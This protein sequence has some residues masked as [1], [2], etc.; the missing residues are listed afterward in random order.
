MPNPIMVCPCC[1]GPA[2]TA[3]DQSRFE[4]ACRDCTWAGDHDELVPV[5][6]TPPTMPQ[7][8]RV[9]ARVPESENL[10]TMYAPPETL[11]D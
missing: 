8:R 4:V 7:A 1:H 9:L 2:Y 11:E 10:L 5:A 3:Y 6:P